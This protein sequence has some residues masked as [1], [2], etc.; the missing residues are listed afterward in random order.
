MGKRQLP[1]PAAWQRGDPVIVP[2]YGRGT[3][4]A[5]A[6]ERIVIS[7]PNGMTKEFLPNYVQ[8]AMA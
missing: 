2:K 5:H 1:A 8:R 4:E 3:V 7:F 6:Q